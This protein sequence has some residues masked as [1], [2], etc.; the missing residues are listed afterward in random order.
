MF[1]GYYDESGTHGGSPFTILAGFV[2][3]PEH[4]A[5]FEREWRKVLR[6]YGLTHLRA[7]HLF[8]R[9][10][11]HKNWKDK[12]V[13]R[14]PVLSRDKRLTGILSLGDLAVE[15]GTGSSPE[16]EKRIKAAARR[17]LE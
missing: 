10:K 2:A 6:N 8:H 3:S 5:H 7:K 13:R 12:Q 4:W 15:A 14:L 16:R 9:Q 1:T 11:Q 17:L